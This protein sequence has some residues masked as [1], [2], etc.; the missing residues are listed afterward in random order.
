MKQEAHGSHGSPEK[1]VQINT[2]EQNYDYIYYK[3]WHSSSG[4]E[5]F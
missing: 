5:D 2:F 1:P 3:N 4:G